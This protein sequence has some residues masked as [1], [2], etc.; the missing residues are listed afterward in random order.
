MDL[1]TCGS[2][3]S[4]TPWNV[5]EDHGHGDAAEDEDSIRTII[6]EINAVDGHRRNLAEQ[7]LT[8]KIANSYLVGAVISILGGGA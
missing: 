7:K 3:F 6:R 2:I 1:F 8:K 4:F 5:E